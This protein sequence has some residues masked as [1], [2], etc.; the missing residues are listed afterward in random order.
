VS[1]SYSN[2]TKVG[3][4]RLAQNKTGLADDSAHK[5]GKALKK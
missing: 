4:A 5:S 2:K 3:M 1:N